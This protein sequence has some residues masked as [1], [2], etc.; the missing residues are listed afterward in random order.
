MSNGENRASR[1]FLRRNYLAV[2][3]RSFNSTCSVSHCKGI[4]QCSKK[5]VASS[6]CEA[7]FLNYAKYTKKRFE[8]QTVFLTKMSI[9]ITNYLKKPFRRFQTFGRVVMLHW[10]KNKPVSVRN[11]VYFDHVTDALLAII[12]NT[13]FYIGFSLYFMVFVNVALARIKN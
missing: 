11:L 8:M 6:I 9:S 2:T 4:N 13:C 5:N 1:R 10:R 12:K 3:K 7:M